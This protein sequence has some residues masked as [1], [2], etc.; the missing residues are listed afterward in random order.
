MRAG[1][2]RLATACALFF[3]ACAT[4]LSAGGGGA[5]DKLWNIVANCL[6]P[7][8]VEYCRRCSSPRADAA[9]AQRQRCEETTEVWGANDDYVAIRDLKMCSCP[10][11]FVHG[12]ALPRAKV[13]G[14]GADPLPDGIWSFAWAVAQE[15]IADSATIALVVN[16]ARWRTQDQLHVH[17][18]R[19]RDSARRNLIGRSATVPRLDAVWSIARRLAANRPALNDYSVLVARNLDGGFVVLVGENDRSLERAYTERTCG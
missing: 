5:K 12:L 4:A 16:S 17:L 18:V 11:G 15:K 8:A 6:D 13:K 1:L 3:A 10:A 14:I 19:L 7:A 9:C 2:I